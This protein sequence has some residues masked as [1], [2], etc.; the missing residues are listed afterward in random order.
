MGFASGIRTASEIAEALTLRPCDIRM[1]RDPERRCGKC[2]AY[3]VKVRK[4]AYTSGACRVDDDV[5]RAVNG[6]H[7]CPKFR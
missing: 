6:W 2:K 4:G 7:V 1:S 5:S 3:K